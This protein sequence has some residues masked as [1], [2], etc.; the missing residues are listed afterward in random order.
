MNEQ[1]TG[2]GYSHFDRQGKHTDSSPFADIIMH[3]SISQ[4]SDKHACSDIR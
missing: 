4:Q 3:F 1:N 2:W